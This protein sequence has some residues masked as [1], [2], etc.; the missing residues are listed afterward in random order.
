MQIFNKEKLV[1]NFKFKRK[2]QTQ[3]QEEYIDRKVKK[4]PRVVFII[5][6][7]YFLLFTAYISWYI[8]FRDTYL[9]SEVVGISMKDTL[10]P[11]IGQLDTEGSDDL[12]Y[13]NIKR[14]PNQ[15]DIITIG[16]YRDS[17]GKSVT[18]IKRAIALAGNLVTIKVGDDGYYHVF[19][20]DEELEKENQLNETYVKD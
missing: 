19:T 20:Y 16:G 5:F 12:V 17:E 4:F 13:I 6:L 3:R 2:Q 18:L 11:N 14:A 15:F 9:L 1:F 7:I 10:N 8:Y